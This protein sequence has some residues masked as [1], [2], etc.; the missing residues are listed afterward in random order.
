[1]ENRVFQYSVKLIYI[2]KSHSKNDIWLFNQWHSIS[3]CKWKYKI[4]VSHVFCMIQLTQF[5]LMLSIQ[6]VLQRTARRPRITCCMSSLENVKYNFQLNKGGINAPKRCCVHLSSS[7][8]QTSHQPTHVCHS[9]VHLNALYWINSDPIICIQ[10][11]NSS[12]EKGKWWKEGRF[13]ISNS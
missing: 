12:L 9:F 8:Q 5:F 13:S 10:D 1:M 6:H 7:T 4:L 3:I 2:W 11:S